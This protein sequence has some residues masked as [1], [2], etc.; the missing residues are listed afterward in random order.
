MMYHVQIGADRLLVGLS[1]G[2][3]LSALVCGL[4]LIVCLRFRLSATT[5]SWPVAVGVLLDREVLSE[6]D[7]QGPLFRPV[8]RYKYEVAGRRYDGNHINWTEQQHRTYT[9]ARKTLDRFNPGERVKIYYNPEMPSSA[10][11]SA[12]RTFAMPAEAV[13]ASTA[14]MYVSLI[15]CS[16]FL[17]R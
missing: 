14:I 15:T 13:I 3:A 9:K 1:I 4:M 2:S 12:G 6:R 16:L 10:V 5:G 17:V 8:V 11:L 7:D